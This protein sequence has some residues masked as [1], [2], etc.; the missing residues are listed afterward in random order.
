MLALSHPTDFTSGV[1]TST[2]KVTIKSPQR[3]RMA[4]L[5]S[6]QLHYGRVACPVP[7]TLPSVDEDGVELDGNVLLHRHSLVL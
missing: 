3:N 4:S 7:K 1:E 5:T 2:E 6:Q